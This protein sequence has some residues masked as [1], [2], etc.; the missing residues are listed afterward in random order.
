LVEFQLRIPMSADSVAD[1]RCAGEC[2]RHVRKSKETADV[3]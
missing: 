3:V 2:R 1:A